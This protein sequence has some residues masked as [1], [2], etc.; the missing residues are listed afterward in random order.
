MCCCF[1]CCCLL[2]CACCCFMMG[3][4]LIHYVLF[5]W[6]QPMQCDYTILLFCARLWSYF[7]YYRPVHC[8]FPCC[9]L[10]L[11]ACCCFLM[12]I[13]CVLLWLT[14]MERDDWVLLL[15]VLFLDYEVIYLYWLDCYC[16]M[17]WLSNG[18]V[19]EL[20]VVSC[21]SAVVYSIWAM[22]WYIW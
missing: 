11:C 3:R 1:P 18:W 8:C 6:L 5:F 9:C 19:S 21:C 20:F 12:G 2:L 4:I 15:T 16:S 22:T 17:L 14:T 7:A 13:L 10:L